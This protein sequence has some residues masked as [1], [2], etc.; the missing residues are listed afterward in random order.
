VNEQLNNTCVVDNNVYPNV[1]CLYGISSLF[2]NEPCLTQLN[3]QYKYGM[4]VVSL[5]QSN[6]GKTRIAKG[7]NLEEILKTLLSKCD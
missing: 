3:I 6:V 2:T 4:Y 7:T 5:R 1:E